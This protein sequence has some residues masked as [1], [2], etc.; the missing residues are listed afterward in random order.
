M[1]TDIEPIKIRTFK[2]RENGPNS[3]AITVPNDRDFS[4]GD[5]AEWC[6]IPGVDGILLRKSITSNTKERAG[7]KDVNR[8]QSAQKGSHSL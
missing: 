5:D 4:P 8:N 6:V 1:R 2:I 3:M 7:D